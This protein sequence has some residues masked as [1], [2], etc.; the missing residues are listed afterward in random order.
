MTN[1]WKSFEVENLTTVD[2]SYI[3]DMIYDALIDA[4][5]LP[6]DINWNIT[7]EFYNDKV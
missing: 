5:Y 3:D 1:D 7:V 2:K 4:G 6:T